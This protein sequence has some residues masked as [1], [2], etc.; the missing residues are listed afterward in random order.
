MLKSLKNYND[1]TVAIIPA[2]GGSNRIKNKN[3]KKIG[4]DS[5]IKNSLKTCQ[6]SGIFDEI[7]VS[8]DSKEIAEE[9]K[10]L[11]TLIHNRSKAN[12]QSISSTESVICEIM[13]DLPEVFKK[14]VLIY[15]IQCTSPFLIK[16]DLIKSHNLIRSNNFSYDCM[17]SGYLFNKFIWEKDQKNKNWNPLNYNP[18]ERPR[19]QEKMPLFIE[20]GA[21]YVFGASNFKLTKCRIHGKVATF[22]ME[23]NRSVDI[24]L[25]EDLNYAICLSEFLKNQN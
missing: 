6:E 25:P 18:K 24:D 11:S 7:I 5:L 17:I 10:N 23:E 21:F 2:R 19:S 15:L 9:S 1:L 13:K 4:N 12:S 14:K 3:L 20:N 8:T 16:D 22:T